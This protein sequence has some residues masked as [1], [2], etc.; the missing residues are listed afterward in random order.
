MATDEIDIPESNNPKSETTAKGS[1][2]DERS[3]NSFQCLLDAVNN[4]SRKTLVEI[5]PLRE[6]H[7]AAIVKCNQSLPLSIVRS[8]NRVRVTVKHGVAYVLSLEKI[9]AGN[10]VARGT[11]DRVLKPCFLHNF[12]ILWRLKKMPV[13]RR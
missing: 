3:S 4:T 11:N 5:H 10:E 6:H 7:S 2:F 13:K 8:K 1:S 12:D 9:G